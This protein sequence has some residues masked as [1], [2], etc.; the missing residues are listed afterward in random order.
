[1]H[2]I[3]IQSTYTLQNETRTVKSVE[4][5]MHNQWEDDRHISTQPSRFLRDRWPI[6]QLTP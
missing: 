4:R 3:D 1:L 5:G 2:A 6:N